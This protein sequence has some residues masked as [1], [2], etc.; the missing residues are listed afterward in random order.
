MDITEVFRTLGDETRLRILNLLSRRELCL[1]LIKEVL[2]I[3][4][5]NASKH[6]SR[7]KS[8]GIIE[9]HKISQWCFFCIS[10][11]F[12]EKYGA[13]FKVLENE[14]DSSPVYRDDIDKLEYMIENNDCCKELIEKAPTE[15]KSKANKR[16][17]L[18]ETPF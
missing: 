9:C 16:R 4:Q 7:L 8:S 14:W 17:A 11:M 3:L 5:P 2:G 13:L 10:S 15:D 1:C 6:L 18:R 12:R